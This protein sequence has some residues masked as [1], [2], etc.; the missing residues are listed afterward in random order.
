MKTL[1]VHA[2]DAAGLPELEC[3]E[4]IWQK[5]RLNELVKFR[6]KAYR[7]IVP[8]KSKTFKYPYHFW[9]V[10]QDIYVGSCLTEDADGE[11]VSILCNCKL[12]IEPEGETKGAEKV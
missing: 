5:V 11:Y 1:V 9:C 3:L 6:G 7:R 12:V 4:R 10:S 2:D 8:K